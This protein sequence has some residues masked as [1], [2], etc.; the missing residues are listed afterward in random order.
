M[1]PVP[2]STAGLMSWWPVSSAISERAGAIRHYLRNHADQSLVRRYSFVAARF[3]EMKLAQLDR[4]TT[5]DDDVR[6]QDVTHML[7]ALSKKLGLGDDIT[8]RDGCLPGDPQRILTGTW[9]E[10]ARMWFGG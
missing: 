1:S 6:F 7:K 3:E 5:P 4:R 8:D 9:L 10:D 2:H